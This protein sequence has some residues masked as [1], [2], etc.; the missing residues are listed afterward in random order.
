MADLNKQALEMWGAMKP[1]IDKEIAEK[2]RGMVQ[3]RKAK[4]TT[5][6]SL[7]TNKIGVTE[8][9]GDQYFVPFTTSLINAQVGDVVW[10]EFMFGAT[11]S[12]ATMFAGADDKDFTVAGDLE[13]KGDTALDGDVTISGD[14]TVD[15]SSTFVGD[16]EFQGDVTGIDTGYKMSATLSSA[17]WYRILFYGSD[18]LATILEFK[19]FIP[20]SQG[21]GTESGEVH[22]IKY[23]TTYGVDAVFS[24]EY[25]SGETLLIDKIRRT[26]GGSKDGVPAWAFD[27]HYA[28][29]NARTVYAELSISGN[30]DPDVVFIENLAAVV[31]APSGESVY[32]EKSLAQR[33]EGDIKSLCSINRTSG[34][35]AAISSAYR[36]GNLV[37]LFIT[38]TTSGSVSG[39]SDLFVGTFS[40]PLPK[41]GS[42]SNGY[43]S[44]RS[45]MGRIESDGTIRFR[46]TCASSESVPANQ[47]SYFFFNY[48]TE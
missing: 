27:I 9:F 38:T 44:N 18:M 19:L 31:D 29:T 48:L 30:Y 32:P 23:P 1:M 25:S 20:E 14:M 5:A 39:G 45:I 2:T 11:N 37:S 6:P 8:P 36:A 10:V 35:S 4:V 33:T 17:G 43:Y 16:V 34:G 13:V 47:N 26:Y 28:G 12:F 24:D 7:V 46:V 22:R 42:I 15:G 41:C 3:R 40:G 21:T